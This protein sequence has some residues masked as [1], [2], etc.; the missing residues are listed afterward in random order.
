MKRAVKCQTYLYY[1]IVFLH[2]LLPATVGITLLSQRINPDRR[3]RSS[4]LDYK[5]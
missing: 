5:N 2:Y 4:G 1:L 3:L